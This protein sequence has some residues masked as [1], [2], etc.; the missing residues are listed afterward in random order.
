MYSGGKCIAF[1][2]N[3][4]TLRGTSVALYNYAH[5]NETILQNKSLIIT[6]SYDDM[7]DARDVDKKA[8]DKFTDRFTVLYFKEPSDIDS[9]IETNGIDILFIEKSGKSSDVL[10]TTKCK[11]IIHC[12][13]ETN[14]P[15]G[16]Y[17]C[18]LSEWL[19]QRN[20]T[21]VPILH[22]M[23]EVHPTQQNFRESMKIPQNATV[24]GSYGGSD[25]ILPYVKDA[26][27]NIASNPAYSNIYF[28]F[29]NIPPFA[30]NSERLRFIQGT[31]NMEEKRA[32]IN[33]CDAMVYGRIW[34]ETFGLACGEFSLCDKPVIANRNPKDKFHIQTLGDNLIGHDSYHECVN[35]L[36]NFGKYNRDVSNNAY[37]KFTP[38]IIMGE[39][40]TILHSL[41]NPTKLS[42]AYAF[43]GTLPSYSI[44][45]VEQ[46]RKFFDGPI[47][48]IISDYNSQYI[49]ILERKYAVTIVRYD[50]VV[51]TGFN[52]L[53]EETYHK[54][55]I[56][57]GLHGREKLFIY[58][59]E[60]F[61]ILHSLMRQ[62]NIA[63]VFF[64]ELDNLIYDSPS[65]W[66]QSFQT[67]DM[68]YMYE[69][70]D[71]CASGIC[72]IKNV[73]ILQHCI[74]SFSEY[75]RT[76][77]GFIHEMGALFR[78]WDSCKERVQILPTHWPCSSVPKESC[79]GYNL[80]NTIFDGAGLGIF[81]GGMD[82]Y[83]TGGRIEKWKHHPCVYDIDYT[84][85]SYEWR[86]DDKGRNIPY[87]FT[88]SKWIRINNLHIHSKDLRD[89]MS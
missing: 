75:I 17:Y 14:D 23:V 54:F 2:E 72:Y 74:N 7:K 51:D 77:T 45:T 86:R 4:L 53:I 19:N 36:T 64:L 48:F 66:I 38:E 85:Y 13:F 65:K 58:S 43:I 56:V 26:I 10:N 81:I 68:A 35:I 79:E 31:Q 30:E 27:V 33:T 24:F 67:K 57:N 49:P 5:Y 1:L 82:P 73:D 52:K 55:A 6:R 88:G 15:H 16:S 70:Y 76:E 83:H 87:V 69:Q 9:L 37:K 46:A 21:N 47:Y 34:G 32:F 80:Y 89:N 50:E 61:Y 29:M 62:R 59:F 40:N 20:S 28:L 63:N 84:K 71:R 3:K 44:D 42:L 11:T 18:G 78:F 12:V 25:E 39:F 22:Y 41:S 8:Y 60:R